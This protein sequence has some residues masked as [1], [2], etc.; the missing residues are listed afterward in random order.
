MI[1]MKF[2]SIILVSILIGAGISA[3]SAADLGGQIDVELTEFLL[4]AVH[5]RINLDNESSVSFLAELVEEDNST[6]YQ[7]NETLTINLAIE[8]NTDRE[9]FIFPRLVICS[10]VLLRRPKFV[11]PFLGPNGYFKRWIAGRELLKTVNVVDSQ[12]GGENKTDEIEIAVNFTIISETMPEPE[13]MTLIIATLGAPFPGDIN[14]DE[15]LGRFIDHK[16]VTLD[17]TYT[18]LL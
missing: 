18:G 5:P 14:G 4:G 6:Y 10:A 7:V 16:K 8:D 11:A 2:I 3:V 13:E 17:V 9:Q 1:K 12:F 15:G